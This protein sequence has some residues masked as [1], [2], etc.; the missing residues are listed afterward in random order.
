MFRRFLVILLVVFLLG[1][2]VAGLLL[3][4]AYRSSQQEPEF[5]R[6]A[7]KIEP[8][9][10]AD[11]SDRM[12]QRATALASE[13][14]EKPKWQAI[15]TAEEINGW[16]AVDLV[17]NHARSLPPDLYDPRVRIAPGELTIACQVR[18]GGFKS[19]LSLT[20]NA[21]LSGPG[22]IAVE[23]KKA[24]AGR[25]P[26][27]L[28]NVL[29]QILDG[30]P[31]S[32][33]PHPVA[34]EGRQSRGRD[35]ASC[36]GGRE[37]PYHS[38]GP[39]DAGGRRYLHRRHHRAPQSFSPSGR[40][41]G[42][43]EAALGPVMATI[44]EAL[45][46][47]IQHHQAGRL[48]AAEQI[49]RQI[50]AVEP[51]HADAM[52][53]LGVIAHQAGK[54]EIAVESIGR[55]I[56]LKGSVAAF[57]LNLGEA[58]RALQRIPEAVACY[59][60]ALELKPDFAEAQCNL[61][62]AL[63]VQGK[64]AEAVACYR[65]ALQL[66]P[67]HAAAHNNLGNALRAQGKRDEA[68]ACYRRALQLMPDFAEAHNNL[69]N[70]LKDQG[71]LH[72]ALACCRRALEL[73][74]DFAEAHHNLGAALKEQGNLDQA[75]AC[76]RRAIELKPDFAEAHHNL[77][78]VLHDQG[79]LAEAVACYQRA[80]ELKPDDLE[81]HINL[82]V[83]LKDEGRLAEAIACYRRTLELKPDLPEAH[84]NLGI[85]LKDQG[86]PDE[87][88]ACY[89]RAIELKPDF[90]EAHNNLGA[91][92]KEQGK[93]DEAADCYRRAIELKP[94]YA[95]AQSNLGNSLKDQGKLDEAVACYRRALELKPDYAEAH[96]NLGNVLHDQGK[97]DEAIACHGRALQLKP[98]H[99]A[100]LGCLVNTLQH[101]CRWEDLK[102]LSQRMIEIVS[103]DADG[104]MTPPVS[105]FTFF[106]LPTTTTAEQQLRCARQWVDR[107]LQAI[108]GAGRGLAR[109]RAPR[110]KPKTI[111]GY[112][113]ADFHSHATAYLIAELF[114][115]H[116]RQRFE[117]FGYSC[118]ADDGSLTR[119]R[120]IKGFDRFADLKDASFVESAQ[121]IAADGVDILVDLK[122]YTQN[123]RTQILALRRTRPGQL[124]R[125][126][127]HDGRPVHGLHPG[128]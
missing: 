97:L 1:L 27:P 35:L 39:V 78:F 127:R 80:L 43:G 53:L 13:L 113:S 110:P 45:A 121:R 21:Y 31:A 120:L 25:L 33:D 87:A 68:L 24:R 90:A 46:I 123:A 12:L 36:A 51:N 71:N 72:E 8:A 17:K 65:R 112:L 93:L 4:W 55:A 52:H 98:D 14:K 40:G 16:L 64:L 37:Q 10:A 22:E 59:R 96:Y 84:Y 15:F 20:I 125:L 3:I 44:S 83:A 32:G 117:V 111:L 100:S 81:V 66:K 23:I 63:K 61:G 91:A 126:S 47:A 67:D 29:E 122:G 18:R 92:L 28:G 95:E 19:V 88:I 70:A 107:S 114:E 41:P 42:A 94:D 7:L 57:H 104:G 2:L 34:A 77:G 103:R 118:G 50:L 124:S 82:G 108:G 54:H 30:R 116:D 5:Y 76:Y 119:R 38:R 69:G 6:Q 48:Q 102:A 85:A 106:A 74:P 86:K 26:L 105:P 75:V 49:Y 73:K 9:K 101:L 60:R 79:R 89:R 62:N 99:T 56:G 109:N 11:Q 128:R 115:K 58:Y